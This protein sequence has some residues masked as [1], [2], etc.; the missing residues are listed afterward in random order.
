M[1]T[2]LLGRGKYDLV[3]AARM[4]RRDPHT[5]A[6]WTQAQPPLHS[7]SASPHLTFL[8]LVSLYVISELRRR[9]VSIADIRRGGQ[10]LAERLHTSYPFAH[11]D[12]ASVG[13]S[14]FGKLGDWVDVGKRGQRAFPNTIESVLQPIAFGNDHLAQVWRPAK[15]V[16]IN[17]LVQAGAPCIN[18]TRVPTRLIADL[19][20][21]GEPLPAIAEDLNL[22]V[23][24]VEAAVQ[25][26]EAA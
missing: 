20:K 13:W 17:P 21:A 11:R 9:N 16:W 22:D 24:Q 4:I 15:D 2:K 6:R 5:V 14:F 23:S 7:I 26:E 25:Y 1:S 18:G 19:V 8:D 12:L 10:Y 3:E